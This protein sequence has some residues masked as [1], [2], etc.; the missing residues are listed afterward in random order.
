MISNS[1][2]G[3]VA[4]QNTFLEQIIRRSHNQHSNFVLA[5]AQIIDYPIVYC[6]ENFCK[7]TGYNRAEIIHKSCTC[8]FLVGEMTDKEMLKKLQITLENAEQ[9]HTEILFYRKNGTPLW[10]LLFAAP[11]KDDK[12]NIVLFLLTFR[13]I[14]PIKQPLYPDIKPG[15]SKFARLARSVTRSR[16]LLQHSNHIGGKTEGANKSAH[17]AHVVHLDLEN[18]PHYRLETPKTPLHIILHYCAFKAFWDW[19]ILVLTFYTAIMVPFNVAFKSKTI[20]DIGLLVVDAVVDV[21]FFI[22]I[23][24]NFHTTFV[25]AKGEIVS[26]PKTIR[27]NYLKTWF[28]IDLLSCLP[29]DIF[30]AFEDVNEGIS[31]LFSA[32]KVVRLLR[33]VRVTRKLDHYF[34]YAAAFLLLLISIFILF[35]HWLAC[36]W[37]SIGYVEAESNI[38]YGWLRSVSRTLN[39]S[40]SYTNS[41]PPKLVDGPSRKQ[42]YISSLYFTMTCL[43][44]V[45]FG[46]IS[47]NTD[48]E[49]IFSIIMMLIGS[50]LYATIFGNVTTIFQQMAANTARYHEMLNNVRDFMKLYEVPKDLSERVMDYIVSRWAA[51]KGIDIAKVFTYCPKDMQA[52]ICV[53]L[54]RKVFQDQAA[55][56]LA[57]DGCLRA[58]AVN[59]QMNH[60]A[61]GDLI[62]HT[63]ESVDTLFFVV[64][65]SLEV[66]QDDEVVAVLSNGDVFGDYFWREQ[67]IGQ[68]S[69]NVRALTYCDL[70]VIKR[71]KLLDVLAFYQAF[72]NSFARNLILNY[73]LRHRIVFRKV[74]DVKRELE[75]EELRKN[76]PLPQF[77]ENHPVRKLLSRL[78][79]SSTA[80]DK[81]LGILGSTTNSTSEIKGAFIKKNS[82]SGSSILQPNRM[83]NKLTASVAPAKNSDP[84]THMLGDKIITSLNKD[85]NLQFNIP[86][87]TSTILNNVIEM[88]NLSSIVKSE[89]RLP[90]IEASTNNDEI[91]DEDDE[92]KS[93]LMLETLRKQKERKWRHLLIGEDDEPSKQIAPL[94][95]IPTVYT[96]NSTRY[97]GIAPSTPSRPIYEPVNMIENSVIMI[98]SEIKDI[99][100]A[101]ERI[102]LK[103]NHI[104]AR[105]D[106]D[107]NFNQPTVPISYTNSFNSDS[108][109]TL[110]SPTLNNSSTLHPSIPPTIAISNISSLPRIKNIIEKDQDMEV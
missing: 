67:T 11:I 71:D 47:P 83:L 62:C 53:H 52:D 58:L 88:N 82:S 96:E 51:T 69:A 76:Q 103:I 18:L 54:N 80:Q 74:A 28:V 44:T 60:N 13:D 49:K 100:V 72:A 86:M 21:I 24:L 93:Q 95:N 1:R 33:L 30:S 27:M 20:E 78:R 79:K 22:D 64:S 35:G 94:I 26:D 34:E 7:M 66:I 32:L 5:N 29:Y 38:G 84:L 45:G 109:I 4:P 63:G 17:L 43:T 68:S 77:D 36:I 42:R 92:R 102:E 40:F 81:V 39:I 8:S 2:K 91:D 3:L 106:H 104:L 9:S 56:R 23:V 110:S 15:L 61:P 105:L 70:H 37:Y 6:N 98:N 90:L 48:A 46:N 16:A 57:S 89:S 31:S 107:P 19:V 73:N 87:P 59:F 55:F 10:V 25:G 50:L 99:K 65:G 12:E 101:M 75:L 41:T 97:L 85:T 14:T 108:Y